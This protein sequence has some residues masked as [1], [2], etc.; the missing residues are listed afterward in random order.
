[1]PGR[2]K[3]ASRRNGSALS[4]R[5]FL[6]SDTLGVVSS[7]PFIPKM[8]KLGIH[9]GKLLKI[10]NLLASLESADARLYEQ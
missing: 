10:N 8:E 3:E 9:F 2:H 7:T 6:K 5:K 4:S 1:V